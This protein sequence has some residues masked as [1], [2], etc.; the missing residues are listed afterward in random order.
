MRLLWGQ[1]NSNRLL[2]LVS[3]LYHQPVPWSGQLLV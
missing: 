1:Q 3:N 2:R